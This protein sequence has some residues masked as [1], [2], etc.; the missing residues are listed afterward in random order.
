[1]NCWILEIKDFILY[2][3]GFYSLPGQTKISASLWKDGLRASMSFDKFTEEIDDEKSFLKNGD[4]TVIQTPMYRFLELVNRKHMS[5]TTNLYYI[6]LISKSGVSEIVRF[7]MS[8]NICPYTIS[9]HAYPTSQQHLKHICNKKPLVCL[10]W[11]L[12]LIF[13]I[14]FNVVVPYY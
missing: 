12:L 11:F 9:P 6:L 7:V 2:F 3:L 8:R 14:Y 1:M 5:Y 10:I 4:T 13:V